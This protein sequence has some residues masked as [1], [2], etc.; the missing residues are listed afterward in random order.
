MDWI[1]LAANGAT[2]LAPAITLGIFGYK[3]LK[4]GLSAD[5]HKL[6]ERMDKAE[7]NYRILD[8]RIFFLATGRTLEEA[9]EKEEIKRRK[10][11]QSNNTI[12]GKNNENK[13]S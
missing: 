10:K 8:E 5:I 6:A 11:K 1:N 12:Q 3:N 4:K 2:I 7:D 9:M 13:N